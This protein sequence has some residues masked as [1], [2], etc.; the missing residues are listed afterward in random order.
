MTNNKR[1]HIS[2][3]KIPGSWQ[4]LSEF[5]GLTEE[6]IAFIGIDNAAA[7]AAKRLNPAHSTVLEHKQYTI[8]IDNNNKTIDESV[9]QVIDNIIEGYQ[10]GVAARV[11]AGTVTI[12]LP[13]GYPCPVLPMLQT[14]KNI[15]S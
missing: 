8:V 7:F 6:T 3:K 5:T 2:Q 10:I 9:G 15:L 4:T 1:Y 14:I 12:T 11:L 13:L